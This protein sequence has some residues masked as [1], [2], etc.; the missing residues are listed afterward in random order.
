MSET[1]T[2]VLGEATVQELREAVRGEILTPGGEGYAEAS[3]I[4]NGAHDGRRPALVVRC[5]G[6]AD[7]IAAVG[8][9]RSNDLTIAVRGGGHSV[10]G[11][12]TCNDGIVIDLSPMNGVRVDMAARRATV[13]GGAVR[14]A[15]GG[16]AVTE[17]TGTLRDYRGRG[18]AL[19]AKRATLVNAAKRG[20]ELVFTEND[21]TNGPMLRV[22]E[23]L[24]YRPIGSTVRWSRP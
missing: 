5:T 11:F 19:L 20:V 24:G 12:S 21:E 18:L 6:A 15:P 22:N 1:I 4:W 3:R 9:A 2:P 7:V 8:F 17:M 14:I 10:A 23:K 13:G 16:R